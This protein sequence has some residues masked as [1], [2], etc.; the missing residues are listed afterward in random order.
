VEGLDVAEEKILQALVEE[1]FQPQGA[2][3]GEGEEE[4]GQT[5]AGAAHPDFA[6]VRPV[7]LR[8][9][10]GEKRADAEKLPGVGVAGR[11]LRGGVG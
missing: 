4:A 11:P 8:Q 5:S 7:G 9:L 6:E 10:A 3:V 2:A 1:K